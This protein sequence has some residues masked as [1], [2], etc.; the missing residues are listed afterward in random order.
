MFEN[1]IAY[2][3]GRNDAADS[4]MRHGRASVLNDY[5]EWARGYKNDWIKQSLAQE[6]KMDRENGLPPHQVRV[7]TKTR[8]RIIKFLEANRSATC[9][10]RNKRFYLRSDEHSLIIPT[11]SR[12]FCRAQSKWFHELLKKDRRMMG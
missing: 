7:R 12:T 11:W 5:F 10:R 6:R 4:I 9:V 3:R 8:K 1:D 2:M